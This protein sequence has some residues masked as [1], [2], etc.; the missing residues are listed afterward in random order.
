MA[1]Y[2]EASY[3]AKKRLWHPTGQIVQAQQIAAREYATDDTITLVALGRDLKIC[4]AY[5]GCL[6]S[7]GGTAEFDLVIT[8]GS[9]DKLLVDGAD[10]SAADTVVRANIADQLGWVTDSEDWYLRID[11]KDIATAASAGLVW[12]LFATGLM[13]GNETTL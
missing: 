1:D 8:D 13:I 3:N 4:D 2:T 12:G 6:A 9:T 7:P 11:A 10:L 5:I